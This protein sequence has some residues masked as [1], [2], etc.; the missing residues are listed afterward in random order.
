[1]EKR[2]DEGIG[3]RDRDLSES[4]LGGVKLEYTM[5]CAYRMDA[6]QVSNLWGII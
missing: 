3:A 5:T 6:W 1:M 4:G 2:E